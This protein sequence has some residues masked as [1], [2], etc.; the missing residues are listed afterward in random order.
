MSRTMHRTIVGIALLLSACASIGPP[1]SEHAA[2]TASIALDAAT[3]VVFGTKENINV[4]A[5]LANIAL[6]GNEV[7][8]VGFGWI[9]AFSV[10]PGRHRLVAYNAGWPGRCEI[11][12]DLSGGSRYFLEVLPWS[13][14]VKPSMAPAS[15]E[16]LL[17]FHV[18][19]W[20][21]PFGAIW[22]MQSNACGGYLIQLEDA[23]IALPKVRNMREWR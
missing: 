13:S 15:P 12:V 19:P 3:L 23:A 16:L 5:G 18:L 4:D 21:H 22:A 6:D 1:F 11:A 10:P 20:L 9:K 14:P 8:T 17:A 7:G 2:S